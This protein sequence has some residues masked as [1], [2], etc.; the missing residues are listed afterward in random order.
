MREPENRIIAVKNSEGD[1]MTIECSWD[2][3]LRDHDYGGDGLLGYLETALKFFGFGDIT[4]R[5][6]F[7][8]DTEYLSDYLPSKGDFDDY[9][10]F[11]RQE[12]DDE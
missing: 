2:Q 11:L 7:G 4:L 10:E 6:E 1:W 5:Y 9:R 8:E 3:P 12:N